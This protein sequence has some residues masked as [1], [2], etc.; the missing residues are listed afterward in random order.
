MRNGTVALLRDPPLGETPLNR[1]CLQTSIFYI[2]RNFIQKGFCLAY[3]T[4]RSLQQTHTPIE[5]FAL[6]QF[7]LPKFSFAK[8]VLLKFSFAKF[9]LLKLAVAKFVITKFQYKLIKWNI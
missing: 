5:I 8:L 1:C 3:A 6:A 4:F 9:V 7:S 2:C